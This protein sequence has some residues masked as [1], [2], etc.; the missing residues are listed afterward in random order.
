MNIRDDLQE[1]YDEIAYWELVR[2]LLVEQNGLVQ[3][4]VD[5]RRQVN[6]L[7]IR[8]NYAHEGHMQ[9]ELPYPDPASDI[10]RDFTGF[11]AMKKYKAL[12]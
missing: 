9:T 5:L 10:V 4:I 8:L 12:D 2:E 3:Q 1:I 6:R 7:H 11:A